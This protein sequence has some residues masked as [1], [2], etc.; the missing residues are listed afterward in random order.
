MRQIVNCMLLKTL[1]DR[2][3][4]PSE[5]GADNVLDTRAWTE[6]DMV[7]KDTATTIA[8]VSRN[9]LSY[10]LSTNERLVETGRRDVKQAV[11]KI[12]QDENLE[13]SRRDI[14]LMTTVATL[15]TCEQTVRQLRRF[16]ER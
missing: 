3:T 14:N 10:V 1:D 7:Y 4:V 13:F 6:V 16:N 2:F 15:K 8:L 12:V 9:W 11:P 5:V